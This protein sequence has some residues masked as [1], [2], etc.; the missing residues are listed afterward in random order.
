MQRIPWK[1]TT[2]A[3]VAPQERW[4]RGRLVAGLADV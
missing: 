2:V 1:R 4:Q 3:R